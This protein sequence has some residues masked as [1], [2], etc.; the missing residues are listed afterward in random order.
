MRRALDGLRSAAGNSRVRAFCLPLILV[1]AALTVSVSQVE[2]GCGCDHPPPLRGLVYPR[3]AWPDGLINVYAE[4]GTSPQPCVRIGGNGGQKV[5]GLL[6][7]QPTNGST[8]FCAA[9]LQPQVL[10]MAYTGAGCQMSSNSKGLVAQCQ[11]NAVVYQGPGYPKGGGPVISPV[12]IVAQQANGRNN[13]WFDGMVNFQDTFDIDAKNAQ[14][15]KLVGAD[16]VVT[17]SDP[18]NP[19]G[20]PLQTITLRTNCA[21]PLK[22][23]DSFGALTL[24]GFTAD[25]KPPDETEVVVPDMQPGPQAVDVF[26]TSCN[27]VNDHTVPIA[28]DSPSNFT[29]LPRPVPM[30]EMEGTLYYQVPA[31]VAADGTLLIAFDMT[32]VMRAMQFFLII[33]GLPL[34]FGA[35]DVIYYNKDQYNLQLFTRSEASP[36]EYL[37]GRYYGL[38]VDGAPK[39]SQY[40]NVIGYWRH[41][42]N[43]YRMAHLPGGPYAVDPAGL[44]PDGTTHIDHYYLV[45]SIAGQVANKDHPAD[46]TLWTPLTPGKI[47]HLNL[48]VLQLFT[49][50]PVPLSALTPAQLLTLQN[51]NFKVQTDGKYNMLQQVQALGSKTP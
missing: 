8:D 43:T 24:R 4:G 42:F 34:R 19:Q 27:Q 20:Q 1:A 26:D 23:G 33:N 5:Q 15:L 2:A 32:R 47:D 25:P 21:A 7:L 28:S 48:I 50:G 46:Q 17:I 51:N 31:V 37:W 49:D 36:D 30:L 40:S 35:D 12:H 29:V 18:S 16:T 45:A 11:G 41:E 44:H 13:V 3:F 22:P 10:T 9:G 14:R 6:G 38:T 39:P